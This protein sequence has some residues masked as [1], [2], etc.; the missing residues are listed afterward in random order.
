MITITLKD[1]IIS[2]E[3]II[4]DI[5]A[6]LHTSTPFHKLTAHSLLPLIQDIIQSAEDGVQLFDHGLK[7]DTQGETDYCKRKRHNIP[8]CE[9][10]LWFDALYS[11]YFDG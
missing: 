3:P 10:Q 11:C 5:F 7:W 2:P 8:R 9:Q 4:P 1:R 6:F